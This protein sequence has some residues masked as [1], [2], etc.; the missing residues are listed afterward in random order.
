MPTFAE[1]SQQYAA[2][3]REAIAKDGF[4]RTASIN[5]ARI[6]VSHIKAALEEI[7]DDLDTWTIDK[8]PLTE[9]QK[10]SIVEGVAGNLGIPEADVIARA[11]KSATNDSHVDMIIH[12]VDVYNS[13]KGK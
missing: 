11:L 5:E 13:G 1:I 3:I 12:M 2:K 6:K 8:K 10:G 7:D 9:G 4:T